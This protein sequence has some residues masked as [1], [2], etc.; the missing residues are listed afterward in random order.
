MLVEK[1]RIQ[2]EMDC[3]DWMEQALE[4]PGINLAQFPQN[5]YSKH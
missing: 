3:L 1:R 4:A 5:R 2:L